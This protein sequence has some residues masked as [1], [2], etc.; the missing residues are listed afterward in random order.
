MA[1]QAQTAILREKGIDVSELVTKRGGV[2]PKGRK[3]ILVPKKGI[4]EGEVQRGL[5][6]YKRTGN[7]PSNVFLGI[8]NL[9]DT[10]GFDLEQSRA[11]A[12]LS[13]KGVTRQDVER[14]A[15]RGEVSTDASVK[16]QEAL[17][18]RELARQRE[19]DVIREIN[20]S[21][22]PIRTV[23]DTKSFVAPSRS[24]YSRSDYSRSNV[25]YKS[26]ASKNVLKTAV[27]TS[28]LLSVSARA[29]ARGEQDRL[30]LLS[31][32]LQE[33]IDS[34]EIEFS[35]ASR[36]LRN[37][38]QKAEQKVSSS[39]KRFNVFSKNVEASLGA[40]FYSKQDVDEFFNV[41]TEFPL[42]SIGKRSRA[43]G[44]TGEELANIIL[45][46]KVKLPVG[47]LLVDV[48]REPVAKGVGAGAAYLE[49][50]LGT[51]LFESPKYVGEK[52]S[53]VLIGEKR[54][55]YKPLGI[56]GK[57]F[58]A[59]SQVATGTKTPGRR[60]IGQLTGLV[61]L[62]A[63]G[64]GAASKQVVQKSL[65]GTKSFSKL[66]FKGT[67]AERLGKTIESFSTKGIAA[68]TP[69][70]NL[71]TTSVSVEQPVALSKKSAM[72]LGVQVS[73]GE[74]KVSG[75]FFSKKVPVKTTSVF[76]SVSV[77]GDSSKLLKNIEE[78]ALGKSFPKSVFESV[79][80]GKKK[81]IIT[82]T[83][84]G[85]GVVPERVASRE[86]ISLRESRNVKKLVESSLKEV[87]GSKLVTPFESLTVSKVYSTRRSTLIKPKKPIEVLPV[88]RK[89]VSSFKD[90]EFF[91][92]YATVG[93]SRLKKP[94]AS[95]DVGFY[96][97]KGTEYLP[98]GVG[99]GRSKSFGYGLTSTKFS[100]DTQVG[101]RIVLPAT[102]KF[103]GF[104]FPKDYYL[105]QPKGRVGFTG[106]EL[107]GKGDFLGTPKG[108]AYLKKL[109][110]EQLPDYGA[111]KSFYRQFTEP[112]LKDI[113]ITKA[114]SAGIGKVSV[115]Q[116][117]PSRRGYRTVE[118]FVDV[119]PRTEFVPSSLSGDTALFADTNVK[120]VSD[121]FLGL[122]PSGSFKYADGVVFKPF[123]GVM[124]PAKDLAG[125][126]NTLRMDKRIL[127][128]T[129][130]K[131]RLK[132]TPITDLQRKL[133]PIDSFKL[134]FKPV[135]QF[136]FKTK[137]RESLRLKFKPFE[138]FRLD[139]KPRENQFLRLKTLDETIVRPPALPPVTPFR[140]TLPRFKQTEK[141]AVYIK[142]EPFKQNKFLKITRKPLA[143][144][145]ALKL[146][147]KTLDETI[148]QTGFL[149]P[150]TKLKTQQKINLPKFKQAKDKP[151]KFIEQRAFAID[152]PG[153]KQKLKASK[154][155]KTQKFKKFRW[156]L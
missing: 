83:V 18:R 135:Q 71:K 39:V 115:L 50:G 20:K 65:E 25:G 106:G 63:P 93:V 73:G 48:P 35:Q 123:R 13:R 134:D 74:A 70:V 6:R 56:V 22:Q 144:E 14:A 95:V 51:V 120:V 58:E 46:K 111:S 12:L 49:G 107:F 153:E 54:V 103:K 130:I 117:S 36:M 44:K 41:E 143:K 94:V 113:A 152:T 108:D 145:K 77:K 21:R 34:G 45:P 114:G 38:Q 4:S 55:S 8:M 137:Q 98:S 5:E 141:F 62:F 78:T 104:Q 28:S 64:T 57:P 7:V 156:K 79:K 131:E 97:G 91:G 59:V 61:G 148:A 85:R 1:T 40:G 69:K 47:P 31:K 82:T 33:K 96:Y 23:S 118:S 150:T 80:K 154:F 126:K 67:K 105:T 151:L 122:K 76:E 112:S 19:Q 142:E 15:V 2:V 139:F 146:L 37:A 149:I 119:K 155:I 84:S 68:L 110:K 53:G 11:Q 138:D 75:L 109:M 99:I 52:L 32:Q 10:R 100:A 121:S 30:N 60:E 88:V 124:S 92:E 136:R 101:T 24:D 17:A 102:V 81:N 86:L 133:K 127:S 42:F 87:S 9:D 132:I 16:I 66:V 147:S 26:Q 90:S 89:P 128:P 29:T 116:Y 27:K 43:A 140:R 3:F 129:K 125:F 72:S